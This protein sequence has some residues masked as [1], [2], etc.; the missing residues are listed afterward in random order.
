MD[1][2]EKIG[3]ERHNR[4]ESHS[5]KNDALKVSIQTSLKAHIDDRRR[6]HCTAI[7]DQMEAKQLAAA[8]RREKGYVGRYGFAEKA[9]GAGAAAFD[10]KHH[11]P[12][13]DRRDDS[14]NRS[15]EVWT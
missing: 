9:F 14:W 11:W 3:Y 7:A 5:H 15:A 10:A 1:R 8:Q 12:T 4:S 13:V 6:R 2:L